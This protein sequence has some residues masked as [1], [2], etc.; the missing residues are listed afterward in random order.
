ME[1]HRDEHMPIVEDETGTHVFTGF[2]LSSFDEIKD[3][4]NAGIRHFRIDGIFHDVD[5]VI[6]ALKLYQSVLHDE[7]KGREVFEAYKKKY[8]QDHV[9]H[10]FYYTKTS[11]VKEG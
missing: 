9:T 2:T 5:Y 10:G 7:V 3:M 8:G 1:E 6:E 4:V 11:K